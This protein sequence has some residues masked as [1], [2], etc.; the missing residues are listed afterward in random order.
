MFSC[1]PT[2]TD[3]HGFLLLLVLTLALAPSLYHHPEKERP[4]SRVRFKRDR[5][6]S[7]IKRHATA[8]DN[9]LGCTSDAN[10]SGNA[11][12]ARDNG[13]MRHGSSRLHHEPCC[14]EE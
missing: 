14:L 5:S 8:A 10:H 6:S 9:P 7:A 4:G 1:F 2:L 11:V 13:P 12:F 3:L